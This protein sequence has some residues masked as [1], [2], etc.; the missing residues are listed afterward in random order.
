MAYKYASGKFAIAICDRCGFQYKLSEL[1]KL[2]IKTKQV[3]IKVCPD[4]YEYD[5]PQLKL[6][7]YPVFDPQALMEP[8]TD[9]SLHTTEGS[10]YIQWG[11]SPVGGA[12]NTLTPNDL[13]ATLTLGT[14]VV[15]T[16]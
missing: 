1:K 10:R 9:T 7:M 11:W 4:C 6:G 15:T 16:T 5:H 14:I 8:R 2:I 13:T 3:S 12:A